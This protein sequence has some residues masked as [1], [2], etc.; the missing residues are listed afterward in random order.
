MEHILIAVIP[1]REVLGVH[2][3]LIARFGRLLMDNFWGTLGALLLAF[4]ALA[5]RG[6]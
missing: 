6:V 1:V 3:L 5:M 4:V 2:G